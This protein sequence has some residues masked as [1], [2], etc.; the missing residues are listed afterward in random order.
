VPAAGGGE[1]LS[2][3]AY[4]AA[5][6]GGFAETVAARW[7][8][9][10]DVLV[11]LGLV[12]NG[13][14]SLVAMPVG[15]VAGRRRLLA[16]PVAHPRLWRTARRWGLVVG[17]P[18]AVVAGL[19]V[20]GPADPAGAAAHQESLRYLAAAAAPGAPGGTP[21]SGPG[22]SPCCA[23]SRWWTHGE[24]PAVLARRA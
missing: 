14:L 11:A 2:T 24:R 7:S 18:G 22:G 3:S 19:L 5:M 12:L 13:S 20:A 23:A 9:Y 15:F 1:V 6:R 10:P 21:A 4:D 8:V 16:D 17:V